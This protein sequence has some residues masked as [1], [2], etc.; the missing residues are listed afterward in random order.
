M[1]SGFSKQAGRI[2][3]VYFQRLVLSL[4]W[5][6]CLIVPYFLK[7]P[8]YAVSTYL[9]LDRPKLETSKIIKDSTHLMTGNIERYSKFQFSFSHWYLL[10]LV[11]GFIGGIWI[12]PYLYTS[13]AVFYEDLKTDF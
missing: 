1:F 4:F 7:T 13:K 8:N 9:L 10:M 11:T 2:L 12:L 3:K 6:I 5:F